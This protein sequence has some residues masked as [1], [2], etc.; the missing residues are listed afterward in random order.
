VIV[1]PEVAIV[2]APELV[3]FVSVF[4]RVYKTA[5]EP[6]SVFDG[7]NVDPPGAAAQA[8]VPFTLLQ[9]RT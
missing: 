3:V 2:N 7:V 9:V 8:T 1:V 6:M 4:P 5:V